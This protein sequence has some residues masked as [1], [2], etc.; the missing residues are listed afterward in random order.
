MVW[1]LEMKRKH[2]ST[3]TTE[4]LHR[5]TPAIDT[6]SVRAAGDLLTAQMQAVDAVQQALSKL[7]TTAADLADNRG[8]HVDCHC[9]QP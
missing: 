7:C 6:Q 9:Q 4:Q 8:S 3:P 5:D 1:L 2:T